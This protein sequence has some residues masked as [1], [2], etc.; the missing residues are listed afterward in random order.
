MVEPDHLA[1]SVEH[2]R[3][4]LREGQRLLERRREPGELLLVAG[5]LL[6]GPALL[7]DLPE[8]PRVL[9]GDDRLGREGLEEIHHRLRKRARRLPPDHQP[10]DD[11]I[12]AQERDGEERSES[13]SDHESQGIT[14]LALDIGDLHRPARGRR[15]PDPGLADADAD[16]RPAE[17]LDQLVGH[18]VVRLRHEHVLDLVELVD[19]AGVGLRELDRVRDDAGEDGLDVEARADRLTHVAERS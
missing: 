8:E 11:A 18:A 7:V 2:A 9:D 12:L 3:E 19:R 10:A 1:R 16:V 6:E 14:S 5:E 15:L 17:G 4:L 13:G